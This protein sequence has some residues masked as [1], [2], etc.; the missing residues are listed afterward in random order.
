MGGEQDGSSA[1]FDIL[2]HDRQKL[3][4]R[5]RIQTGRR[6]V[7]NEQLRVMRECEAY[8]ELGGHSSRKS[9]YP[10]VERQ[11]KAVDELPKCLFVPVRIEPGDD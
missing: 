2:G 8:C 4:P 6:L 7:K 10:L 5:R 3:P 11:V 1:V 9:H